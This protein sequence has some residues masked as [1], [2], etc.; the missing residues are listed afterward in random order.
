[1]SVCTVVVVQECVI[2]FG[3]QNAGGRGCRWR[4]FCTAITFEVLDLKACKLSVFLYLRCGKPL[5]LLI[6]KKKYADLKSPARKG[7]PVRFRLRAP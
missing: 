7:V 4:K 6:L 2:V 3:R 1:M 5:I